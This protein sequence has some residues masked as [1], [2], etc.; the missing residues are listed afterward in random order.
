MRTKPHIGQIVICPANLDDPRQAH[1][2][3]YPEAIGRGRVEAL[4]AWR[5]GE[6]SPS[7]VAWYVAPRPE[8]PR[9][10]GPEAVDWSTSQIGKAADAVEKPE[11]ADAVQKGGLF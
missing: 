7:L 1:R 4:T 3:R 9:R 11:P 10:V 8:L 6:L 2:L 5:A